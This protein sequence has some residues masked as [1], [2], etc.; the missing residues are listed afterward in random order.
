MLNKL[1]LALSLLALGPSLIEAHGQLAWV[2][3]GGQQYPAWNL[4]D[5]YKAAY[6]KQG[7]FRGSMGSILAV[8]WYRRLLI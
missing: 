5:H 8:I 4:D 6:K 3:V 1:S 7:G 2:K